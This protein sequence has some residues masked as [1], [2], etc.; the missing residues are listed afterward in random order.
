[1]PDTQPIRVPSSSQRVAAPPRRL[2]KPADPC[3]LVIFGAGGDLTKRLVV[4]ALYNLARTG[5]LPD[6]FALIGVNHGAVT[7]DQWRDSLFDM[8][9]TFVG[10]AGAEFDVDRIDQA[11]WKKLADRMIALNGDFTEPEL[12]D[13]IGKAL[14]EAE[15]VHGTKGNAIFYLAVADRF[16]G[17]VVDQLGKA[18]LSQPGDGKNGKPAFWR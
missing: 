2:P 1:M 14:A 3:A 7:T 9:K 16:F 18:G 6:N 4:P 12:Y 17:T 13:K 15:K 11:A 5:V 10:N 8:L